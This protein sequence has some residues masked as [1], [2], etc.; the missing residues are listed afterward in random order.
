MQL[1]PDSHN[2]KKSRYFVFLPFILRAITI[3]SYYFI[4]FTSVIWAF[5]DVFIVINTRVCANSIVPAAARAKGLDINLLFIDSAAPSLLT[6][7][8]VSS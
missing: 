2:S 4:T 5:N 6:S 8:S 7:I 1:Y 3:C